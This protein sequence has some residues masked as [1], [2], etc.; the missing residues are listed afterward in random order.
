M[1]L[2]NSYPFALDPEWP[3]LFSHSEDIWQ[4]L[5][6]VCK[7]F[8]LRRY[9]KFNSEVVDAE[10]NP[11]RGEWK[12]KYGKRHY[13][14]DRRLLILTRVK[15]HSTGKESIDVCDFLILGTGIFNNYR[16]ELSNILQ[17]HL[18]SLMLTKVAQYPRTARYL[19]RCSDPSY[20]VACGLSSR[21]VDR[22]AH[23]GDRIWLHF[24]SNCPRTSEACEAS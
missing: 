14:F 4:Y 10:W 24:D 20:E 17:V 15:N 8:D 6:K 22:K 7:A 16:Y 13:P 18:A 3:R 12:V 23:S 1:A 11:R 5:N 9:M 21:T 2:S 19:Q